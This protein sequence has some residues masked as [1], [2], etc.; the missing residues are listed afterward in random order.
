MDALAH[1][2][3][4]A[5]RLI[6]KSPTLSLATIITLALGIGLNAGVFSVLSGL[7]LRPRVT[8]D[9]ESFV[10][11]QP[12]YSGAR[13]PV[14]ESPAFSTRDYVA[15]RDRTTTL[16]TLAA[17][18]VRSI[19]MG[20]DSA[21]TE[22]TLL[23][24]CDFF[25]AYGLDRLERGRTFRSEECSPPG[26]AVAVISDELWRR[27]F[28]GD[29]DVLE[30]PLVLNGQ[31]FT[32]VGVTPPAFPGRLRGGGVWIPY[33]VEPMVTRGASAFDDPSTAWL[34]VDGRLKPRVSIAAAASELSVLMRQQDSLSPGRLTALALTNGAL[35]HDP[36]VRPV[37]MFVM[38]LILGSVGLVLLIACG[39]VTLLLLSRAVA[40]QRE[41]A[42]RLAIGC[43]RARL[44][45]MLLTESVLLAVAGMPASVWLAWQ[46]PGAMRRAF[47]MMPYYPMDPDLI[48]LSYLAAASLAAGVAAGLAPALESLR[49][50]LTPMLAGQDPLSRSGGR[51]RMRDTLIAAQIGMTL[52]LL[53]GTAIFL[54]AQR[55][56]ALRDPSVDAA[57]VMIAAYQPP[58]APSAAFM[59]AISMRMA[60]L[61]GVRSV[62]YAAAAGDGPSA[63]PFIAVE[64][65]GSETRRRVPLSVVSPSYFE[66]MRQPILQG[67]GF[68][69]A[70]DSWMR[71]LVI[72]DAL[73]RV[74]WQDGTAIGARVAADDGRRFE[75]VGVVHADAVFTAGTADAI[76]GFVP[77]PAS[78]SSGVLFLR[79][80]GDA[81]TLQ[82]AVRGVLRDM[83]PDAVAVPTTLAAA[84]AGMASKFMPLVR[85]VGVLGATAIV[86]AL[87]GVYGVVSFAVGRRTR[88]IGI[89]IALGATR[90]DIIRSVV[91]SAMAPIGAGIAVGLV[92]LVPA[93][94]ALDRVFAYTP[95]PLRIGDPV[96]YLVVVVS[97]VFV[98]IATMLVPARRASVIAP[99]VALRSE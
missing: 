75:V 99:S 26:A 3:R 66:T 72:S 37:A 24:S 33:S 34:W 1:D 42:T 28:G 53:A 5:L 58:R 62:A 31:P 76:Q 52:V 49:Q 50:R 40:R 32:I 67:H 20:K 4:F 47:P 98:A 79:F 25:D 87:V 15:L 81:G 14:H 46:M 88:E 41:I 55:A 51:S 2:L 39:N 22:L 38:P 63:A 91:T 10:H 45:R 16:R 65:R 73:A 94:L 69:P 78:P 85:M 12:A 61:P 92:L 11:L 77:P 64:G 93:G 54:R 6:R 29:P 27:Q 82:S 57:H 56:I 95:I 17:W 90:A 60:A 19:R 71:P 23:V 86:L 9:P 59:A 97:I 8:M 30:K 96:P 68:N 74:W 44:V 84:D 48:V 70:A 36:S 43:S 13:V 18:T 7:L 35:I 89:R 21:S 80:D 83:T